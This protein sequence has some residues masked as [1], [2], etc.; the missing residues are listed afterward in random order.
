MTHVLAARVAVPNRAEGCA[1]IGGAIAM[2]A[3]GGDTLD[4][5][6]TGTAYN[7]GTFGNVAAFHWSETGSGMDPA[8]RF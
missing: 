2:F 1:A 7:Y 3:G 5:V 6:V 4:C 8:D